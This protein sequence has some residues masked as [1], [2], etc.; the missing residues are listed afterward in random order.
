MTLDIL[1]NRQS[2]K[3][4]ALELVLRVV[5]SCLWP[6][7]RFSPRLVYGWRNFLLRLLGAK[8]GHHVHIHP[9]ARIYFPWNFDVGAESAL[10][11][12]VLIYNLGPVT[13]GTQVTISHGAQLCA[14][15]HDHRRPDMPLLK[16]PVRIGDGAWICTQAYVGPGVSIGAGAVVGARAVVVSDVPAW[17]IV[18]GNPSRKIGDRTLISDS[19]S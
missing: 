17:T 2:R 1:A 11:E 19:A 9:R 7:Y 10:A 18:A 6:L 15:S 8:I 5:W 3:Y 14:G 12:D 16:S 13:L 4:S